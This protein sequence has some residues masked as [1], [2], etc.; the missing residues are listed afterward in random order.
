MLSGEFAVVSYI[1]FLR[2]V[3][4]HDTHAGWSLPNVHL[5]RVLNILGTHGRLKS[6]SF[7]IHSRIIWDPSHKP[8][9]SILNLCGSPPDPRTFIF[10]SFRSMFT[11][12]RKTDT[13]I[14]QQDKICALDALEIG[15]LDAE[16]VV[17][18]LKGP[19][20][21]LD[22]T[23]LHTLVR[24]G[25]DMGSV[26]AAN[27]VMITAESTLAHIRERPDPT[28][29]SQ[30]IE[31]PGGLSIIV[32]FS[33]RG[34]ITPFKKPAAVIPIPGSSKDSAPSKKRKSAV[35]EIA[36]TPE[37]KKRA[38]PSPSKA[39]ATPKNSKDQKKPKDKKNAKGK[40]KEVESDAEDENSELENAYLGAQKSSAVNDDSDGNDS[41]E[42]DGPPIEHETVKKAKK[43]S[44]S[45]PKVKFVPEGE[46]PERRDQRTIFVGNLSV[47]VAQKRPLLKQLQ[48]HI[49]SYIPTAKIESTRFR[50]VPFQAPTSKLPDAD[51]LEGKANPKGA[52][53]PTKT[54][55]PHDLDRTSTWRSSLKD[56]EDGASEEKKKYLTPNEKKKVAF[57]NQEFHSTADTVNAYIVFAH[58]APTENRP[59]NLPPPPEVLDPYEAARQA[60]RA[61]DGSTFME[62]VIRVDLVGKK[63]LPGAEDEVDMD[64]IG[65]DPKSSVFVGNLDFASKEEDLRVFFEGVVST[66][67]GPP[68]GTVEGVEDGAIKKWVTRVR[69][70]RDKD[71]QL[72]KGFAYVQFADHECVDEVL[73][74]EPLRLKFAKRKLRVQR[75]RTLPGSSASTR[76]ATASKAKETPNAAAAK[77][78]EPIVIPKGD[79]SLGEKLAH[80]PKEARKQY[81]SA[82]ADRVAR[83]L[84]KKKA[85]MTMPGVKVQ[86]KDRDRERVRKGG[87]GGGGAAKQKKVVS[88]KGR[89]RSEKSLEKRNGKKASSK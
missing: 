71:T 39:Q 75:C 6:L 44:R 21:A 82:D 58:S 33:T 51:S 88:K 28:I 4:D 73:A 11:R 7:T 49:L 36:S 43:A 45:G 48:R 72:G 22:I 19:Y 32:S 85:R 76:Q 66:E 9:N 20:C 47:D 5:P 52:P 84:A 35:S 2:V 14:K 29:V 81:K 67:R 65:A 34:G 87:A 83:R 89:V 68:P 61:C 59:K 12:L 37:P 69:I 50:S 62:R 80:L 78:P 56:K 13:D 3:D 1:K 55:R 10:P 42:E 63:N 26:A 41:H 38:K 64:I 25:N 54:A 24:C 8:K 23:Q 18:F 40:A 53:V 86:G 77:R 30:R 31:F 46:T 60:V 74:L 70:V 17:K 16:R 27:D 79:P 57:I 15:G